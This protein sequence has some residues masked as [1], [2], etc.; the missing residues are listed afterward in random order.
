LINDALM[1]C[2]KTYVAPNGYLE[3]S[4]CFMY[5]K[6]SEQIAADYEEAYARIED[7]VLVDSDG[8]TYD[9]T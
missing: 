3:L 7:P 9:A 4:K 5:G 1:H 8:A 6:T 2:I